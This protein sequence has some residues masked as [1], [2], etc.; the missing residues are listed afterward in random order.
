MIRAVLD[1]NIIISGSLWGGTPRQIMQAIAHQQLK[2]ITSEALLEE[3]AEV[4]QRPK[5]AE[6]LK[7]IS[8][9]PTEI[10]EEYVKMAEIFEAVTF[11]HVI[12]PED[13]DDDMVLA[14]AIGGKVDAI[15]SGN[16]HL[17]KLG[18]YENIPIWD[19]HDFWEHLS[20]P[21]P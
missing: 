5:F 6:R 13:P 11:P 3:L 10:V 12:I 18:V 8:R 9:T 17:L 20:S 15:V 7:K 1:T 21:P 14:C 16:S 4:I 2:P 19:V